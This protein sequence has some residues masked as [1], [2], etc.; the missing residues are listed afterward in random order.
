[1]IPPKELNKAVRLLKKYGGDLLV[2]F[3]SSVTGQKGPEPDIDVAVRLKRYSDRKA[4]QLFTEMHRALN[5]GALDLVFINRIDPLLQM[6]IA[7][8]G[9]P[10]YES[11]AGLFRQ[12]QGYATKRHND[13]QRFY[14]A[15][16]QV[17]NAFLRR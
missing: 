8:G 11:S 15:D 1:M 7:R 6:E 16:R 5:S 3:G 10:L 2:L 14:R 12:F 9:R 4:Y 13:A 17:V